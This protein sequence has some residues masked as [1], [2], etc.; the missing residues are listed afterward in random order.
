MPES[1]AHRLVLSTA[2]GQ[3]VTPGLPLSCATAL[4]QPLLATLHT[5]SM[6]VD[7][8][9]DVDELSVQRCMVSCRKRLSTLLHAGGLVRRTIAAVKHHPWCKAGYAKVH[10]IVSPFK[11]LQTSA[12]TPDGRH[13]LLHGSTV[14]CPGSPVRQQVSS[15]PGSPCSSP[16]VVDCS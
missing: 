11:T 9:T 4:L 1:H 7:L 8:G 15:S 2:H 5:L 14:Y 16:T 12:P 10:P 3:A 13:A 6:S